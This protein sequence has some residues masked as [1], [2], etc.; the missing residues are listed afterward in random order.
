MT[1]GL[2]ITGTDTGVGK[3]T[4]ACGL[5]AALHGR[6]LRV[7]VLKPAETGCVERDGVRIAD[8]AER[9][10]YFAQCDAE[11]QAC[12]PYTF[13]EPLA[14]AVAARREGR[15]IDSDV[16]RRFFAEMQAAHDITL[17]EGA[18][19]LLVPLTESLTFADLA[20]LLDL[21]LLVVVGN[22]LGAINHALLTIES[23]R[24]RG[25]HV[26]GYVVNT[27]CEQGDFAAAT[28]VEELQRWLGPPLANV[29]FLGE[30]RCEEP[31][32]QRLGRAL[33]PAVDALLRARQEASKSGPLSLQRRGSG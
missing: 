26:L 27:L 8:D 15:L 18:G 32:R 16:L 13:A 9:L 21:P 29:P 1:R 31:E 20:R 17:V 22:R 23:A 25:L 5:A 19:G 24:T 7:G 12:C 6:G 30:V 3:T 28:N 2:F 33:E 11:P 14:P 10:R 4:I